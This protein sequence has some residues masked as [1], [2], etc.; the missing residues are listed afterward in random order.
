MKRE[1]EIVC[2]LKN[3]LLKYCQSI[4]TRRLIKAG[5]AH[6]LEIALAESKELRNRD[7]HTEADYVITDPTG[8]PQT[9]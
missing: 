4:T 2:I 5:T 9:S 3:R 6:I 7:S 1:L 8:V